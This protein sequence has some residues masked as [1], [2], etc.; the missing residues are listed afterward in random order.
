MKIKISLLCAI[1]LSALFLSNCKKGPEDP[2]ISFRSRKSRLAGEW[3]MKSGNASITTLS[4]IDPPFNQNLAFNGTKV[5]LNQTET[6]GP[7]ILYIGNYSLLLSI[8]KEGTFNFK[9]NFAGDIVEANGRW[10]FE[11]G[12]G[13]IKNKEEVTFIIEEVTKGYTT[14]HV[15]NKQRT[16][17]TYKLVQLKN[18]DLK[19]EAFT[20]TYIDAN[21]DRTTYTNQ[22]TFAQS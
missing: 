12:S 19:I 20:K 17:F 4:A 13:D 21:G 9:E 11:Y 8:K 22:Y 2:T 7:A 3:T 14:G 1:I 15:F 5:E 18:K 6:S 10:H 16:V